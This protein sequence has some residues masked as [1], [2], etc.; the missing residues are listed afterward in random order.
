MESLFTTQTPDLQNLNDAA[1]T[2]GTSFRT[3]IDGH[4]LGIRMYVSGAPTSS[5]SGALYHETSYHSGP[6]L[7][8]K[9]FGSLTANSWNQV[10][11]DAPVAV[12]AGDIYV[13]AAGPLNIYNA[14]P[15]FFVASDLVVDHLIAQTDGGGSNGNGRFAVSSSLSHPIDSFHATSYFIDVMFQPESTANPNEYF[16]ATNW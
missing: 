10:F 16:F 3:T 14:S 1:Y 2:L 13:A 15:Y 6:L 7:D 12:V 8:S 9:L 11:F 4:V 5:P